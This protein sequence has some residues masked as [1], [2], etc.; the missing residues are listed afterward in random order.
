MADS[1]SEDDILEA[2]ARHTGRPGQGSQRWPG[3]SC[4]CFWWLRWSDLLG[5]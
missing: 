3:W 4:W 1:L 5:E 2:V